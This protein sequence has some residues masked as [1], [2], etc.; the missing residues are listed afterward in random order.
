MNKNINNGV[1][2]TE[3]ELKNVCGGRGIRS[4][5]IRSD[6]IRLGGIRSGGIRSGGIRS[7]GIRSSSDAAM[8]L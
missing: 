2:L 6:G 8:V 7:G 1:E 4:D 5:G 3:K